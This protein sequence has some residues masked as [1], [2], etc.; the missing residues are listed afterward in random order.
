M[1]SLF[2]LSHKLEPQ[3]HIFILMY[4]GFTD[5]KKHEGIENYHGKHLFIDKFKE[6]MHYLKKNFNV[7]SLEDV[8]QFYEK[9]TPIPAHSVVITIDDGYQS[10]YS[11][12]YPILKEF[13]L[14]ATIFVTTDF[15]DHKDSLWLDRIEYAINRTSQEQLNITMDGKQE[16]FSLENLK[17]KIAADQ[18]IKIILKR[19]S[20]E[21]RD[22]TVNILE[23]ELGQKLLLSDSMPKIYAPLS[24]SQITQMQE[25]GLISVGDHTCSHTI[26]T[27]CTSEEICEKLEVS[28]KRIEEKCQ[29]PCHLFAYPNGN[30]GDFN[31]H[32][33]AKIQQAGFS[34]ALTTIPQHNDER[35]DIF[36]LNRL[37]VHNSGDLNSFL[38]L[39]SSF[40]RRLS[41]IKNASVSD[42]TT[43]FY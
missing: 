11:L 5:Q 43:T 30:L 12:A 27:S 17:A 3:D 9:R 28:K 40:W 34:C 13:R 16:Q 21:K 19:V 7:I 42:R 37:N 22:L 41:K 31:D 26:L 10:N 29:R 35:S 25:S 1:R 8:V 32:T 33:K 2:S 24:W 15:I 18:S 20:K 39:F 23:K 4:H 36:A 6:Q 14:P 38:R